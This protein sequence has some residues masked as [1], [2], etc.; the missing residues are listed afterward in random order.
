[1]SQ[2]TNPGGGLSRW[3]LLPYVVASLAA[4]TYIIV[5]SIGEGPG[6]PLDDGWIHQTY[7][8]NLAQSGRLEFIPGTPSAGSTA[9]LWTFLLAI[10][11]LLPVEPLWWSYTLGILSLLVLIWAGM[12]LWRLIWPD[13]A[14][15]D[16]IPG[17][18]LGLSWPLLWAAGSGM[19]TLLFVALGFVLLVRFM[20]KKAGD[21][22]LGLLA[23]LLI[24]VRPEGLILV[25]LLGASLTLKRQWGQLARFLGAALVPLLP[26]FLFNLTVSG[27]VWPNTFY[28]K[29]TEYAVLLQRPLLGRALQLFAF[30]LGGPESGWRGI[31]G[32]HFVLLPGLLISVWRTFR[33]D[34]A[35]RGLWR[36]LPLFWAAG[37]VLAYAMRLPVTYQHGRYLWVAYPTWILFGLAGWIFLLIRLHNRGPMG[38]VFSRSAILSFFTLLLLFVGLGAQA[39]IQDVAF[40]QSEMVDVA[41]WLHDNTDRDDLIAAHDIGA[42]GY[43]ARRP[44]LDL[45]GLVSPQIIPLLDDE[46]ALAHYIRQSD[47]S[48]LV[49]APGWPYDQ[50][51]SAEDVE[52]VYRTNYAWTQHQGLNNMAVYILPGTEPT[53]VGPTIGG[54]K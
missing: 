45:A 46:E 48:H 12:R 22:R 19:E 41:R 3:R 4:L 20:G 8:R 6:F 53:F 51:T 26:Y 18:S 40:I 54:Q 14:A 38:R 27:I 39:Y 30:S 21:V 10:G 31:S 16:W 25:I 33:D 32:A 13:Y 7:A 17:V 49:T 5:S 29:Q 15:R 9:P 47:A 35:C 36:T 34:L 24:L 1:M 11:Y 37:H 44:I 50:L 23:G 52:L 28:A 43:F 42:I 2:V